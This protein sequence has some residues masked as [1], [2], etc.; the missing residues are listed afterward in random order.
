M[1][2]QDIISQLYALRETHL[3]SGNAL[4]SCKNAILSR[5]LRT[6]IHTDIHK[7]HSHFS[8]G[9]DFFRMHLAPHTFPLMSGIA[10]VILMVAGLG[11]ASSYATPHHGVLYQIKSSVDEIRIS[12]H[13]KTE[14]RA[15]LEVELLARGS[16]DLASMR[17]QSFSPD[18]VKMVV[19]VVEGRFARVAGHLQKLS[20]SEQEYP[21]VLLVDTAHSADA[22][23][24]TLVQFQ[25]DASTSLQ[26]RLAEA[27]S[28][29]SRAKRAAL[30]VMVTFTDKEKDNSEI[31][32]M[33]EETLGKE[34]ASAR[35]SSREVLSTGTVS[36]T[37]QAHLDAVNEVLVQAEKAFQE[38]NY[39]I[40]LSLINEAESLAANQAESQGIV[41]G[42]SDMSNGF[43]T[44]TPPAYD[45][46]T[47]VIIDQ[48]NEL[49]ESSGSSD[50][51]KSASSK[52]IVPKK[53][54]HEAEKVEEP[55]EFS[56]GFDL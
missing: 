40:T 43:S 47:E 22:T 7:V 23:A 25:Q 12:L 33:V 29:V 5:A 17:N 49:P 6:D 46:T 10:L 9:T 31:H 2:Q 37:E 36:R 34:L 30:A 27:L 32:K 54:V 14:R 55:S 19:G 24:Y 18:A 16:D 21:F 3:P 20:D 11:F 8:A 1:N 50:N 4:I 51:E 13:P 15:S 42:V 44:S 53:A 48:N 26:P 39:R 35:E 45:T 52:R 28:A 56:I 41:E 38:G